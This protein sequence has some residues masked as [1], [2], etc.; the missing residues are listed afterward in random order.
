MSTVKNPTIADLLETIN[1]L[2]V[3]VTALETAKV[4]K[5]EVKEMT[6]EDA[7]RVLIGDLKDA[8]HKAA[9]E[10]LGLTYGQ[11]YSCRLEFTFKDVHKELRNDGFKNPWMK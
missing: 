7:K 11:I 3:R 8:K 4:S 5:T 2:Q 6:K 1:Q 9:A 10:A